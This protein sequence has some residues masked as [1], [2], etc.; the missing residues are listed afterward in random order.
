[1]FNG[2]LF[3]GWGSKTP[4]KIDKYGNANTVVHPH[5]PVEDEISVLPF[6]QYC[7]DNGMSTGSNDMI[8]D[9][10]STPVPFYVQASD[11]HEIFLK[12]LSVQISDGGGEL[13]KF[14]NLSALTNGVSWSWETQMEGDYEL[15]EGI[16][17]NLEFIKIGL[18]EP[19]IDKQYKLDQGGMGSDDTY[20][21]VIDLTATF[22]ITW[23]L[24]L[25]KGS[26]DKV[27]FTVNDDLAGLTVFNIIGYGIRH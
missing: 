9:G 26:T 1:M 18:G 2:K 25:R 6:R 11:D 27:I 5:P 13:D 8:V 19:A 16:K 7:T 10:S 17:T 4:L 3:D 14:G 20:I 15:H 24:R 23:G 12:T 22:G 21:P